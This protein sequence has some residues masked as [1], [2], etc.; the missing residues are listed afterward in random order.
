[1]TRRSLR[2]NGTVIPRLTITSGTSP[3]APSR[4]ANAARTFAA[5]GRP[6][7]PDPGLALPLHDSRQQRAVG[8][9]LDIACFRPPRAGAD[10]HPG[11]PTR[12]WR[13]APV[14]HL[15]I[16]LPPGLEV[17]PVRPEQYRALWDADIDAFHD[18]WGVSEPNEE[19]Y[20]RWLTHPVW[21]QPELWQVAWDVATGE[22]AGQVRTYID[23]AENER[24][25]RHRGYTE[26][27]SVRRPYRRQGL[28]RA[29]IALSLRAQRDA[30]MTASALH[31]DADNLTGAMRVYEE[32]GFLVEQ[33]DTLYRKAL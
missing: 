24:F 12:R 31:V 26:F 20:Q 11:G 13:A 2:S 3:M 6:E 9:L 29:L 10:F 15:Q 5:S 33:T 18:H 27:I 28:A 14:V 23:H 19:D 16:T 17:R 32:C 30:G 21:F 8:P 22:V 1:M 7:S 4:A 25:G